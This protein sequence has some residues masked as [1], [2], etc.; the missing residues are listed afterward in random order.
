MMIL[1]ISTF[2]ILMLAAPL[3]TISI[4]RIDNRRLGI[5]GRGAVV[6]NVLLTAIFV[7]ATVNQLANL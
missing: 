7:I 3:M 1:E 6:E 5:L 2:L 4:A